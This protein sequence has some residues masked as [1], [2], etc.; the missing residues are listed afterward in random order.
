M[1]MANSVSRVLIASALLSAA[2]G[3]PPQ[4]AAQPDTT[5][6]VTLQNFDQRLG[7][8]TIAGQSFTIVLHNKRIVG[9][10]SGNF[11]QT[12]VKLEIHDQSRAF[13]Y[14]KA[15]AYQLEG[16]KF[17]Q[18]VSASAFFLNDTKTT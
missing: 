7:P 12:L 1:R 11:G 15:F 2:W 18:V 3:Q 6:T 14:Q 4:N 13:L 16:T 8:F 17:Q 9:A 10:P 5:S